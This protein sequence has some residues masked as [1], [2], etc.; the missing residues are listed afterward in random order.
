MADK[1]QQ[2]IADQIDFSED[3]PFAELTRIMGFDPRQPA[4]QA[5]PAPAPQQ[6]PVEQVA[7]DDFSLDLEREL[8]GGFDLD[9]A[10]FD[11]PDASGVAEAVS[12]EPEFEASSAEVPVAASDNEMAEVDFDF[13]GAFEAEMAEPQ[14]A[15]EPELKFDG[16]LDAAL[17]AT[18]GQA[19]TAGHGD[20][21]EFDLGLT[22][23][24]VQALDAQPPVP[25]SAVE[26]REP[27]ID[28]DLYAAMA[29][30]DMNFLA[31]G[32]SA[33]PPPAVP[34]RQA[35]PAVA[36]AYPEAADPE[37]AATEGAHGEIEFF[38][39]SDF[40]FV[41]EAATAV[42]P[43]PVV[44][45]APDPQIDEAVFDFAAD[46]LQVE[47]A[48]MSDETEVEAFSFDD[49]VFELEDVP[50]VRAEP[51]PVMS[52]RPEPVSAADFQL[53][54]PAYVPRKLPVSPMDV[55][56][57][58]YRQREAVVEP[59]SA[60]F[61]LEDELNALLGNV[62][63]ISNQTPA[64][65]KAAPDAEVAA[66]TPEPLVQSA[67]AF[68]LPRYVAPEPVA[69][70]APEHPADID[71]N[72][73]WE[74]ED[75]FAAEAA[76]N[77]AE[78]EAEE[79][80]YGAGGYEPEEAYAPSFDEEEP[81]HP[82]DLDAAFDQL[83][84]ELRPA[85]PEPPYRDALASAAI[86]AGA[87]AASRS[88]YDFGQRPY[89]P[90]PRQAA[91]TEAS[92][93]R[94][95]VVRG[96]PLKEDPLDIITQRAEKYSRK[97]PITPYGRDIGLATGTA[98]GYSEAD[99]REDDF[100]FDLADTF[101]AHPEVET[102][103]VADRAIAL[104][105]DLDIPELPED[106]DYP[107]TAYDDLD[108]E[109]SSLLTDMNNEPAAAQAE[110]YGDPLAGD[111][112]SAR[113]NENPARDRAGAS[114]KAG[115]YYA[116]ADAF[117]LDADDLPGSRTDGSYG[118]DAY[119]YDPDFDQEMPQPPL[120]AKARGASRSRGLLIAGIVGGVALVGALGAF[121]LSFGGRTGS[122][123][124]ALVKA[125]DGPVKVKPE[126]TGGRIVPNQDSKVYDTVSGEGAAS[127]PQQEKLVTT[128]EEP[129]DV[130]PPAVVED[131]AATA[132]GKSEDR[133][134]QIV[135]DAASLPDSEIVAVA[136]RKVRTMV[137]KPDGTLVPREDEPEAAPSSEQTDTIA[138]AIPDAAPAPAIPD[139]TGSLAAATPKPA[140]GLA[141]AAP[142]EA[143]ETAAAAADADEA[144]DMPETAP[145]VPLRPADQP[146]EIVGEVNRDQVAAANA[147]NV[148]SG[149]W[150]LQIAS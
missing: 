24:D 16:D 29:D 141:P 81:S 124:P 146:I 84:A 118:A 119:E 98:S 14:A 107:A 73:S 134:E 57:E 78:P 65:P 71:D 58:E 66:Y 101:E 23:E 45:A 110:R 117:A 9:D 138:A 7:E 86:G 27:Q 89:V 92:P 1:N 68:E 51:L 90:A 37:M 116:H 3:D 70:D 49:S 48:E 147:S 33:E 63:S 100:E 106:E 83:A 53:S 28:A 41:D 127:A 39:A 75:A 36:H 135:Q 8:L 129:I 97:D 18:S 150:A 121:A 114:P 85:D 144:G 94:D 19:Q 115:D 80:Q 137:V 34:A 40:S 93:H 44:E 128:A 88:D 120:A 12:Y 13:A 6:A 67:P 142:E 136:P 42:E 50:E 122:D 76:E 5:A 55:A 25:R 74:F 15:A 47:A 32:A 123:T 113:R 46:E 52:A 87:Y 79:A 77:L 133:I 102:V 108:T 143:T 131:N 10:R 62:R 125:D 30:I 99:G 69:F 43:E 54:V 126:N 20:D 96:N 2:K 22:D 21:M 104:A 105:D 4:R 60:D 95:P 31:D 26:S 38:D 64:E 111:A 17:A 82:I 91:I 72:L 132:S 35:A 145:I 139:A 140:P 61:N 59:A 11:A 112:F 130:A 149:Y 103:E 109:F 56:A 148:S